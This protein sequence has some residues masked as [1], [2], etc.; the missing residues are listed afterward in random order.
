MKL[1][2]LKG[3]PASG[4]TTYAATVCKEQNWKRVNRDLIRTMLHFDSWTGKNESVTVDIEKMVARELIMKG[5]NVIVDD[6]NL[7]PKNADMWKE[8]AKS[9]KVEFS[10]K[11][12]DTPYT[13]CM[14]RDLLREKS[15]GE[16]VIAN[17]AFQ[18]SL[19]GIPKKSIVI[20]DIDGTVANTDHRVHFVQ[21]PEGATDFVKDWKAFFAAMEKDT[22]R[23]DVRE[24][25]NEYIETGHTI[26]FVSGRP[27]T[28][29]KQTESWL[30]THGFEANFLFMR[31]SKDSRPD[32]QV[33]S[34][35]YD[36]YFADKEVVKVI[37]DRPSV[38]RMWK[39][40]GLDVVDVG[41]GVEF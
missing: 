24:I 14:Y 12:F 30:E 23:E 22:P 15:V 21:T 38:I 40:K 26:V 20:C 27:D 8:V 25:L 13:D 10:T 33:K 16:H 3:L 34:E 41:K 9:A 36:K 17:M 39:E 28:Y 11:N 4:K 37:D 6:C 18:Y 31:S 19:Q 35:I 29:R 2:M 5:F 1:V 32:T 7:N